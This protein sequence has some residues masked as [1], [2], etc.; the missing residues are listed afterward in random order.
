MKSEA[1]LSSFE[2]KIVE[3]VREHGC[4]VN[5]IFD[6][7]GE[8]PGFS[9][10]IGFPQTVDQPEVI[11]F[12]LPMNVMKFMIN[13]TLRQCRAGL[14]LADWVVVDGLLEGHRCILREV[15]KENIVPEYVNSAMWYHRWSMGT[16]LGAV[17]Q[18]VWPGAVD[19]LFPWEA[20]CAENVRSLQPALYQGAVH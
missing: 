17:M 8:E 16:P 13:D 6:P 12:G 11:T 1:D 14:S 7:D 2:R 4:Q 19:G 18:L 10:S 3:N 15:R 9:Y 5:F 20:G